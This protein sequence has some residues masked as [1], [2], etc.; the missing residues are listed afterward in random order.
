MGLK[1][2]NHKGNGKGCS[3]LPTDV[4][5]TYRHGF[6]E[7]LDLRFGPAKQLRARWQ[8][9]AAAQGGADQLSYM[10]RSLVSR[11]I[12]LERWIERQEQLMVDGQEVDVARYFMGLNSFASLLNR[13]GLERRTKPVA[14]L[15]AYTQ[16]KETT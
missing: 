13:L 2:R 8:A 12:H 3:T 5:D 9:L 1:N 16:A 11:F 4:G 14:N 10:R 7:D 6:L 15:L